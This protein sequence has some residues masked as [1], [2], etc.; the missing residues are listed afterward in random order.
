[1]QRLPK[2]FLSR[3]RETEQ[4]EVQFLTAL[5]LPEALVLQRHCGRG[6][7]A[8]RQDQQA[9]LKR[10]ALAVLA[11]LKPL[12]L[13]PLAVQVLLLPALRSRRKVAYPGTPPVALL[14]EYQSEALLGMR[15]VQRAHGSRCFGRGRAAD[16]Q[17]GECE[18]PRQRDGRFDGRVRMIRRRVPL[19]GRLGVRNW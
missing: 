16:D 6:R 5:F 13:D 7:S 9:V 19:A 15:R 4:L 17:R 11:L 12:E 8:R 3:M 2:A 1:M 18:N 14:F 10:T